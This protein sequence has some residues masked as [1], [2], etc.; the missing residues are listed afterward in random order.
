MADFLL[1][2]ALDADAER[3]DV[4]IV[5]IGG[6]PLL[7]VPVPNPGGG[8]ASAGTIIVPNN[9]ALT[10]LNVA[11]PVALQQGQEAF[12]QSNGGVWTL[13]LVSALTVGNTVL[14][15]TGVAG[16]QWVRRNV[17][18]YVPNALKQT[19][20]FVD[21]QNVS[22]TASDENT[23]LDATHALVNKKEIFR[24]WGYTWSPNIVGINVLVT[25]LS[26]DS[27]GDGSGTDPGLFAPNLIQ[28]ATFKQI[29]VLPAAT[30][31]GTLLAVT[32][33]SRAVG[34]TALRSTFTVATGAVAVNMMLVN[35]TRGNSRAF[36]QRNTGA[37]LWQISQPFAPAAGVGF[38]SATEVD[39]WANGDAITGYALMPINIARVGGQVVDYQAGF[40]G[41][42]HIV[43]QMSILDDSATNVRT[44]QIK[45]ER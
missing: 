40:A 32:A 43:Q 2:F 42:G 30:F 9:A 11:T 15:A 14:S 16:A 1:G 26:P 23:G 29:A 10:A 19:A 28:G 44:T 24:R 13:N 33:K 5:T 3:G 35:A 36:A 31:T 7:V 18:G 21:P 45:S 38:P 25:Y 4:G 41:P 20:W 8:G 34:G 39:T 27:V 37:G 22:G 17:N 6:G 12:V